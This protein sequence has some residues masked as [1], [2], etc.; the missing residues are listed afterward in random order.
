MHGSPGLARLILA[1]LL[2]TG[3]GS[4]RLPGII[5]T[6]DEEAAKRIMGRSVE[7]HGGIDRWNEIGDIVVR[8]EGEWA[9]MG[10]RLQPV[11]ADT[12]YRRSSTEVIMPSRRIVG[13]KHEGPGGSKTVY[14]TP[15]SVEVRYDGAAAE[16]DEIL[17]A[18]AL[19]ADAYQMFLTT[20][21]FVDAFGSKLRWVGTETVD[22]ERCDNVVA[23]IRH[24]FGRSDEDLAQ[25]SIGRETGI[26]R[27]VRFTLNGTESTRGAEVDVTF[28]GHKEID[29]ILWATEYVERIRAPFKLAAHEWRL[30]SLETNTGTDPRRPGE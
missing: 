13:Q 1:A 3:C 9:T 22:G 16:A 4:A 19:V 18:A 17:G 26:L 21:F 11:L 20:P 30:V 23:V 10:P 27:R 2:L 6:G 12:D 24:G 25:V 28:R 15:E 8:Y 5:E 29:G 7:A 14:R